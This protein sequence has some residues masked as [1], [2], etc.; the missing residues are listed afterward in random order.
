MWLYRIITETKVGESFPN[1]EIAL[2][3]FLTHR[4]T[5]T[6]CSGERSFSVLKRVKNYLRSTILETRPCNLSLLCIESELV[7][8][9]NFEEII[10]KFASIKARKEQF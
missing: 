8:K 6:N 2:R 5:V 9:L 10:H 7:K 3:L 1:V 4:P